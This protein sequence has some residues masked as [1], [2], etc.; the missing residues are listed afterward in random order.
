ML[1]FRRVIPFLTAVGIILILELFLVR[2]DD[3]VTIASIL[4]G[5]II[6]M[7]ALLYGSSFRVG[8]YMLTLVVLLLFCGGAMTFMLFLDIAWVRHAIAAGVALVVLN[9]LESLFSFLSLPFAY[10][11]YALETMFGY[12]NML[13][14]YF[15]YTSTFSV[16]LFL[17]WSPWLLLPAV[18]VGTLFLAFQTF[19]AH[20][21]T[22]REMLPFLLAVG[23][24]IAEFD[25]AM[26][27]LP[28]SFYVTGLL[29]TVALYVLVNIARHAVRDT[30]TSTVWKRYLIV[31]GAVILLTVAT[32]Q[33]R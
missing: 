1:L 32:S 19:W 30:L 9:L 8:S 28:A 21:I 6:L 12:T 17:R 13:S 29:M 27:F 33:W 10:K 23:L 4:A 11:P 2:T 20:K 14:A 15:L 22:F 25:V 5:W 16:I 7:L 3:I 18:I 26:I 24:L 31:A